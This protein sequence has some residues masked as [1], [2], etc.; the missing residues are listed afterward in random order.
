MAQIINASIDL[1]KISKS[2]IKEVNGKKWL[3]ISI[4]VNDEPD[5]FG[6]TVQ[7][8]ENQSQEERA[9]KKAKNY[10]GNGKI[11]WTGTSNKSTPAPKKEVKQEETTP[12]VDD[13][14]PF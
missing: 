9:E 1:S 10:L 8:C 12:P 13:D 11:A 6:N 4:I 5:Q 14:L 7:I 3:S 2:K